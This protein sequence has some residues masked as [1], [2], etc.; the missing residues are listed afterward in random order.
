MKNIL[1]IGLGRFGKH[2]AMQLNELGH[3][4]MAV[5]SNEERVNKVLD[6]VTNAQIGDS[7]NSYFLNSLGISNFDVCI[8]A[9]GG[10]F[11]NSLET[12]S[13]LKELGAK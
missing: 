3:E 6:Y 2:V 4:V 10:N 8:V 9:I 11:Q 13:L 5:D 12:T 1:L 7:T